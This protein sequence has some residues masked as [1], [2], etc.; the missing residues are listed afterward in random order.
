VRVLIDTGA[1]LALSH[2]RDQYHERAIR[3]ARRHRSAGGTFTGTTLI[4]SE[5]FSHLL[6]L[7]GPAPARE[8]L[9]RLLADPIHGWLEVDARRVGEASE[10]WLHGFADQPFSLVDAVSFEV[11]RSAGIGVA[12]AFDQHFRV[13]GFELLE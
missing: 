10:R 4:L 7:R 5:F 11:M 9:R 8:A 3:I 13:A 1:L 6:Y 2:G 12:F